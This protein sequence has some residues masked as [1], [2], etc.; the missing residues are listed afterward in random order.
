MF[1]ELNFQNFGVSKRTQHHLDLFAK[2]S[3][4]EKIFEC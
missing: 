1:E 4:V 3:I 2:I